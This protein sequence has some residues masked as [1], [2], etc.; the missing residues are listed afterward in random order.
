MFSFQKLAIFAIILAVLWLGFR[1]VGNLE[2]KR[3]AEERLT[4]PSWRERFSRGGRKPGVEKARAGA[5]EPVGDV[6]MIACRVCGDYV[7]AAGAKACG[8]TDCPYP[9]SS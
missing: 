1:F 8:R 7:A 2:K 4:R 3:K 9:R 6:D 5:R